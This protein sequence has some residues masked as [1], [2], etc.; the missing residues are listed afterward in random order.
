M[1]L[2]RENDFVYTTLVVGVDIQLILLNIWFDNLKKG[3]F[4]AVFST[5][6]DGLGWASFLLKPR[7]NGNPPFLEIGRS[8]I[9]WRAPISSWA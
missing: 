5:A 7:S 4:G 2:K 6:K 1:T 8:G 9:K 3:C